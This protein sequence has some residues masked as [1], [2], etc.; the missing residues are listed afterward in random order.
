MPTIE[1]YRT[2]VK[3]RDIVLNIVSDIDE[4]GWFWSSEQESIYCAKYYHFSTGQSH[5]LGK[6]NECHVIA[7]ADF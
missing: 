4:T 1:D 5:G 7:V 2:I 6:D 3:H